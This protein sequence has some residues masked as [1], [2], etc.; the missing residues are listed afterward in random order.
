MS[1][2][3]HPMTCHLTINRLPKVWWSDVKQTR[4]NRKNECPTVNFSP[5]PDERNTQIQSLAYRVTHR[6]GLS[7]KKYNNFAVVPI[8]SVSQWVG[9][10][11]SKE[12]SNTDMLLCRWAVFLTELIFCIK[13]NNSIKFFWCT[14][15]SC[16]ASHW[17]GLSQRKEHSKYKTFA[18]PLCC[19]S[20]R[21]GLSRR[22]VHWNI[23]IWRTIMPCIS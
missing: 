2:L 21:V 5:L 7:S 17:F 18:V 22:K 10:L 15:V 6:V 9:P 11:C 19:A 12:H 1:Y 14:T 4:K 8:Y 3:I 13:R 16:R 20:H 23:K